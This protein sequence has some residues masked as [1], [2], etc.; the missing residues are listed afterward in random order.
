MCVCVYNAIAATLT[1][2]LT[3][4]DSESN[5]LSTSQSS[6]ESID[7]NEI[8]STSSSSKS[9]YVWKRKKKLAGISNWKLRWL[10]V[11]D[12]MLSYYATPSDM[13]P[14]GTI[15][16]SSAGFGVRRMNTNENATEYHYCFELTTSTSKVPI[17]MHNLTNT[18]TRARGS[19]CCHC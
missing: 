13:K 5:P 15:D 4:S 9:G 14:I 16:V 3:E 10:E 18:L 17:C 12:R 11:S 8:D 19:R 7:S 2:E 6:E 1:A